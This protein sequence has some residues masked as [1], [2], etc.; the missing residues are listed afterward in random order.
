[1]VV[2]R[3]PRNQRALTSDRAHGAAGEAGREDLESLVC[4]TIDAEQARREGTGRLAGDELAQHRCGPAL[5]GESG[6]DNS[7]ALASRET[8]H[9]R[10]VIPADTLA[11]ASRGSTRAENLPAFVPVSVHRGVRPVHRQER[12]RAT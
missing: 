6:D 4:L 5:V 3:P 1:M 8:T 2:Q 7:V 10:P 11:D 12:N 9:E